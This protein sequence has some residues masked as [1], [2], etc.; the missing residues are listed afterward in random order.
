MAIEYPNWIP[1]CILRGSFKS[2]PVDT[3][4][5]SEIEG[6]PQTRNRYTSELY[7][8]QWKIRMTYSEAND[9]I[10]WYYNNLKKVL[11]FNFIDPITGLEKEYFFVDPP[12]YSH[13]GGEHFIVDFNLETTP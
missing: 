1:S 7:L 11:S 4:L 10:F 6:F 2:A 3:V 13:D 8:A 9:L 5:S 12:K